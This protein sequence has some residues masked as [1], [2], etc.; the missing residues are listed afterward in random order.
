MTGDIKIFLVSNLCIKNCYTWYTLTAFVLL[1][2][3][4]LHQLPQNI[5]YSLSQALQHGGG[6]KWSVHL[7]LF[8]PPKLLMKSLSM[9]ARRASWTAFAVLAKR[10]DL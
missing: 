4:N 1:L 10:N 8:H 6:V 3:K 7:N 2:Q 5:S 9:P